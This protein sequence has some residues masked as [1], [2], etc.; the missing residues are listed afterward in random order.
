MATEAFS[1]VYRLSI[2]S[3]ISYNTKRK[4][5]TKY[6]PDPKHVQQFTLQLEHLTMAAGWA[7]RVVKTGMLLKCE[8]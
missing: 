1:L 2:L 7:Q 5:Q 4:T 3:S 6:T 8:S